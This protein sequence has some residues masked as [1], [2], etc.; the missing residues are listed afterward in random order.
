[1]VFSPCYSKLFA[2]LLAVVP[3][4][5]LWLCA[6]RVQQPVEQLLRRHLAVEDG[7]ARVVDRAEDG[8][9]LDQRPTET[10][11]ALGVGQQE[12]RV[13]LHVGCVDRKFHHALEEK[14]K[15]G[16]RVLFA[17]HSQ[18]VKGITTCNNIMYKSIYFFNISL[19]LCG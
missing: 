13:A 1:M 19:H 12:G 5:P 14:V 2:A 3:L 16:R 15:D 10:A 4:S 18:D 17:K 11:V 7:N 8:A 9:G 6:E